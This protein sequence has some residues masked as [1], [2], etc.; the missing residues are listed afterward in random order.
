[1]VRYLCNHAGKPRSQGQAKRPVQQHLTT[2]CEAVV[3]IHLDSTEQKYVGT[4]VATEH[5]H[6]ISSDNLGM[7][8]SNRTLNNE[9][10]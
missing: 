6:I 2:G 7:Y 9:K 3:R 8:A 10:K 1:M 5:N 4:K